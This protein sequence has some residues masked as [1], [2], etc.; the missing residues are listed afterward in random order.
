MTSMANLRRFAG[1]DAGRQIASRS[2]VPLPLLVGRSLAVMCHPLLA[3]NRLPRSGRI[4]LA[5][6]YAGLSYAAALLTLL[7]LHG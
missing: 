4:A 2:R 3:W 1:R 7:A 6:G 5:G